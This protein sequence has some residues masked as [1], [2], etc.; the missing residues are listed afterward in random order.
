ME[1]IC[2]VCDPVTI[3]TKES[4]HTGSDPWALVSLKVYVRN[5]MIR[6]LSLGVYM[7]LHV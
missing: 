6:L 5:G 2:K 4:Q 1:I 3:L 7:V